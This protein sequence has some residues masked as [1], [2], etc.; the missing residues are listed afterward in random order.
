MTAVF[1]V[2]AELLFDLATLAI[3]IAIGAA[4]VHAACEDMAE[5][6]RWSGH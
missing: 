3:S 2:A 5:A 1:L 6:E 4:V